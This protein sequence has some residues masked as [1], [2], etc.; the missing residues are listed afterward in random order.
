MRLSRI[1]LFAW[2]LCAFVAM[3]AEDTL[4]VQGNGRTLRAAVNDAL[5]AAVEQ[6]YGIQVSASQHSQLENSVS[7]IN[8][9]TEGLQECTEFNDVVFADNQK[10][11]TGKVSGYR[12]LNSFQEADGR[13]SVELEVSFPGRYI[14][15]EDP[16]LRRR[17]AVGNFIMKSESVSL[18]GSR[19]ETA[20]W[21]EMFSNSLNIQLTQSRKFTMLDRKFTAAVRDE[22]QRLS[23]VNASPADASRLCQ[24]LGTDYLVLGT[25]MF[26]DVAPLPVNPYTGQALPTASSPYLDVAYRVIL[27]P[28]GQ[29]KWA[30]DIKIAANEIPFTTLA[31]FFAQS[32]ELAATR[33]ADSITAAILPFEIVKVYDDGRVIIGEGGRSLQ[34]GEVLNA[35]KLGEEVCDTRTGEVIDTLEEPLG[36]VLVER[37]TEKLSYGRILEGDPAKITVGT[38][39]RRD[40]GYILENSNQTTPTAPT[41]VKQTPAGGIVVPF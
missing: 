27:A 2:M 22:L 5:T 35:Y 3:A 21:A 17:M 11:S 19:V 25:I 29:I 8:A 26:C 16:D 30:D 31:D 14:V 40:P 37:V 15:G 10:S 12:I 41:N 4:V 38:R 33:V 34:Q 1:A 13:F 36:M 24:Q 20:P 32:A 7:S 6:R 9:T 39:L 28:T 23:S 18:F